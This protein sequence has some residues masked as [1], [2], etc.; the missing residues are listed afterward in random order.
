MSLDGDDNDGNAVDGNA[1]DENTMS[2]TDNHQ[3]LL[4]GWPVVQ[5]KVLKDLVLVTKYM[6]QN[7]SA[8]RY[9]CIVCVCVCAC[10]HT[11]I[12]THIHTYTRTH[13]HTHI[14]T[15]TYIHA[16]THRCM[17]VCMCVCMYV[18]CMHV[19]TYMTYCVL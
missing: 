10:I 1:V 7:A 15:H 2:G 12:H 16:H 14:H 17:Y 9:V 6:K 4:K 13:I 18:M 3:P 8:V 5:A 11:Y 19:Y